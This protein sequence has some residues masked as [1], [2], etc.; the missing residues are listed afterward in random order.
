MF[1]YKKYHCYDE[2]CNGIFSQ[3]RYLSIDID[4]GIGA[5]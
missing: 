2:S 1:V 5:P 4:T 3:F